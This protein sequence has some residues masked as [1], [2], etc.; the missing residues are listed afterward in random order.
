MF[1]VRNIAFSYRTENVLRDVSFVVSP[2]EIV[3][4]VGLNGSGKSTLLRVLST[5]AFPD[6]GKVL[7]DG[8]DAFAFPL[9]YRRQLGY[10]AESPMLYED[11]TIREYLVYRA[12]L[13][14][15]PPKRIRRRL[16]E[17]TELC[18][19]S[20]AQMRTPIQSL[21]LGEQRRVALADA[22]LL[23]PR[24]LLLDNLLF[25]LDYQLRQTMGEI[26]SDAAAFSSVIVTGHELEDLA[27]WSTR[28]LILR[29]G[30][31]SASI[32]TVGVDTA[33]LLTRVD[34]II[35]GETA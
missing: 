18:R 29:G 10:L 33:A 15:E 22:L 25:G 31:I 17:A 30:V 6:S 28:F 2:G 14:G 9:R 20:D 4:L 11:M 26:L 12:H 23:R 21:S 24:V 19:I 16:L 34:T 35:R 7:A 27:K 5:L 3:S 1:E 32:P 13:K 8:Q